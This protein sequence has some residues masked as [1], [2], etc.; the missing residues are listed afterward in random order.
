MSLA[1]F[2]EQETLD[3]VSSGGID[4]IAASHHPTTLSYFYFK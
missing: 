2:C 4:D 1:P 3:T